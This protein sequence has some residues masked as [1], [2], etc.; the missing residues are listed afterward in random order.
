M[1]REDFQLYLLFL[2]QICEKGLR[3]IYQ[4]QTENFARRALQDRGRRRVLRTII[5][6]YLKIMVFLNILIDFH[7]ILTCRSRKFKFS[8][9]SIFCIFGRGAKKFVAS[10][11]AYES[12]FLFD[13]MIELACLENET[14]GFS[15]LLAI[16]MWN[17]RKTTWNFPDAISVGFL[18][19]NFCAG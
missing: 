5:K 14:L 7:W 15:I 17:S 11:L 10:L 13:Q 18:S 8:N 6:I 4:R 3:I 12:S 9:F 16:S 19:S 1:N 2:F